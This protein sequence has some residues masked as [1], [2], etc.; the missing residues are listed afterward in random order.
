MINQLVDRV[1]L[2]FLKV[3]VVRN[4]SIIRIIEAPFA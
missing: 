4:L 2:T 1:G 3:S